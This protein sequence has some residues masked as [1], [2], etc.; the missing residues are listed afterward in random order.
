[1]IGREIQPHLGHT[2][3]RDPRSA[4]SVSRRAHKL[5]QF[6]VLEKLRSKPTRCC[7]AVSYA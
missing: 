7:T 1:M 4:P 2:F 5:F 6:D 3:T